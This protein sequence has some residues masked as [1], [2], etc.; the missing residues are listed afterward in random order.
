MRPDLSYMTRN[1]RPEPVNSKQCL[2]TVREDGYAVQHCLVPDRSQL[3]QQL[4]YAIEFYD[5][6]NNPDNFE[7]ND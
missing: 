6:F 7:S 1:V 5:P 3:D 2:I 4:S